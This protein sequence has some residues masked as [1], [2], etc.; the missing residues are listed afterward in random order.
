M[1]TLE[2]KATKAVKALKSAKVVTPKT[3]NSKKVKT[4]ATP[5]KVEEL[6][7]E[8]EDLTTGVSLVTCKV[9]EKVK[10]AVVAE[11]KVVQP[12]QTNLSKKR[13]KAPLK[14]L[15]TVVKEEDDLSTGLSSATSKVSRI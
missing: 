15:P 7:L 14:S 6:N 8:M 13:V 3:A 12:K 11:V 9:L 2:S 1:V 5:I 4:P 10:Q